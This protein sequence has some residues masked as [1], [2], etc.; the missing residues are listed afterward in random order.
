[1]KYLESCKVVHRVSYSEKMFIVETLELKYQYYYYLL[2]LL[3]LLLLS[4]YLSNSPISLL[5]IKDLATRNLLLD[6][7]WRVKIADFGLSRSVD[8]NS[9]YAGLT[10]ERLLP[11]R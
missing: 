7:Y 11:V 3:L 9:I 10:R 1:M 6:Q 5:L 8:E 4:K 2:L